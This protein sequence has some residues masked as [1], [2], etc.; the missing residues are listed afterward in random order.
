MML[1]FL[2]CWDY[3][4]KCEFDINV[5]IENY[6]HHDGEQLLFYEK[7]HI[8]TQCKKN[9]VLVIFTLLLQELKNYNLFDKKRQMPYST[10]RKLT[11]MNRNWTGKLQVSATITNYYFPLTFPERNCVLTLPKPLPK[12]YLNAFCENEGKINDGGCV[13]EFFFIIIKLWVCISQLHNR[14]TSLQIVFRDFKLMNAF[15]WLLLDLV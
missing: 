1:S 11:W 5:K 7:V 14:L 3:C 15:K 10:W 8:K 2:H 4:W 9:D 12:K 13:K 6:N